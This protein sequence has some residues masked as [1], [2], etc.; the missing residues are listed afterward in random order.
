MLLTAHIYL[1]E[2]FYSSVASVALMLILLG[3]ITFIAQIAVLARFK[4]DVAG[5][6]L[7]LSTCVVFNV[8]LVN[9]VTGNRR[10]IRQLIGLI[11][12]VESSSVNIHK[13]AMDA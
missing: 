12:P 11:L 3:G 13:S 7:A 6:S 4:N 9:A 2:S 5:F 8:Y 10:G 1:D